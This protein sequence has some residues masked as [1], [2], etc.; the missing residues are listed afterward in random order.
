MIVIEQPNMGCCWNE[1]DIM[2]FSRVYIDG[3]KMTF[4]GGPNGSTKIQTLSLHQTP[5]GTIYLDEKGSILTNLDH[6]NG[7]IEVT[8]VPGFKIM[9]KRGPSLS[10]SLMSKPCWQPLQL[11]SKVLKIK[12]STFCKI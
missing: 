5:D 7:I 11:P 6:Q 4:S 3:E 12:K 2:G 9:W 8:N 1:Q 10:D